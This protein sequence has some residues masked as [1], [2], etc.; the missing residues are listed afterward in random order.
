MIL[1][2]GLLIWYIE[3]IFL[4]GFGCGF[5]ALENGYYIYNTLVSVVACVEVVFALSGNTTYVGLSILRALTL[6]E[7]FKQTRF[8]G[9]L[10]TIMS[11]FFETIKGVASLIIL[12][13]IVLTNYALLGNQ[14][15]GDTTQNR[16]SMGTFDTFPSS[17]LLSFV[18]LTGDNW[19]SFMDREIEN[20]NNT[21]TKVMAV[22]FYL[23]FVVVGNFIL[24]NVFLGI[25]VDNLTSDF[26]EQHEDEF[27]EE[28]RERMKRLTLKSVGLIG[29]MYKN[30]I[31]KNNKKKSSNKVS[32]DDDC[33][34]ESFKMGS[35]TSDNQEHDTTHDDGAAT[36]TMATFM[37]DTVKNTLVQFDIEGENISRILDEGEE[38]RVIKQSM[39]VGVHTRARARA[40]SM[41]INPEISDPIPNHKSF[42]LFRRDNPFR[43]NIFFLVTSSKFTLF[44]CTCIVIS[45]LLMAIDDPLKRD[46]KMAQVIQII[47]YVLTGITHI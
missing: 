27:E 13:F 32:S 39:Q 18:L 15:F 21:F 22:V 2:S 30:E 44:I 40:F 37:N 36:Q 23:S 42:C 1:K 8:W 10:K 43:R 47:D 5:Q 14:L 11:S 41:L 6:I 46:P 29:K 26:E 17:L 4:V 38:F 25:I 35:Q 16:D 19:K 12:L 9:Q 31:N 34:V 20:S 3:E 33:T 24:I 7:V 28:K 45:S